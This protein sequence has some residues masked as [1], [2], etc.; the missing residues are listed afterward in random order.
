MIEMGFFTL[1]PH[2]LFEFLAYFIGFRF[3][4][5]QRKG[6]KSSLSYVQTMWVVVGAA[7]GAAA[8][9]K[10]LYWLEDPIKTWHSWNDLYYLMQGKTIVGGLLGGLIGVEWMKKRMG[11]RQST[12]DDMVFPLIVGMVLGRIGCFLTGL[13][14]HT[15]GTATAMWW[16]IDFGDGMARH[17]TQLYEILF[18]CTLAGGLF[19]LQ[20]KSTPHLPS[21]ALFQLFMTSYLLFRLGVDLL[22][23]TPALLWGWS[24]IQV[25]CML[26]LLYYLRL[27]WRWLP[28]EKKIGIYS[29]KDG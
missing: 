19:F 20:Q 15:S 13:T 16:G 12:G 2:M 18:L 4:M 14:D 1:H 5:W 24:S 11:V 28:M 23:P 3:Y 21:G 9:A 10:V 29:E 25:A 26:G 7:V 17:P 27:L 8:G 6:K 22:K